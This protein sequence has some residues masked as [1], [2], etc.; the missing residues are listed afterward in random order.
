MPGKSDDERI[1][2]LEGQVAQVTEKLSALTGTVDDIRQSLSGVQVRLGGCDDT[3]RNVRIDSTFVGFGCTREEA[4]NDFFARVLDAISATLRCDD[5]R[6]DEGLTCIPELVNTAEVEQKLQCNRI[7]LNR[8][9]NG[10]GWKCFLQDDPNVA[11]DVDARCTCVPDAADQAFFVELGKTTVASLF[12]NDQILYYI[13]AESRVIYGVEDAYGAIRKRLKVAEYGDAYWTLEI[14]DFH[15]EYAI[16]SSHEVGEEL[17]VAEHCAA[18]IFG[19][20]CVSRPA[21]TCLRFAGTNLSFRLVNPE[22]LCVDVRE[23][24]CDTIFVKIPVILYQNQTCT[25]PGA[26]EDRAVATCILR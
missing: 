12:A 3:V 10:V 1:T 11:T 5:A 25:P 21:G 7:R 19:Y 14:G 2:D 4:K 20:D 6:C 17:T 16:Q 18:G 22:T 23:V 13:D 24:L 15:G 26:R 8:C 9:P